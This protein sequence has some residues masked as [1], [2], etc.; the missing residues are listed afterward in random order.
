MRDMNAD[1]PADS[2]ALLKRRE[3][4]RDRTRNLRQSISRAARQR[5]EHTFGLGHYTGTAGAPHA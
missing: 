3:Q 4:V 2:D 5:Q 1:K